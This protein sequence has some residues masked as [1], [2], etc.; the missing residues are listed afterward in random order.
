[1][2]LY[3]DSLQ[4]TKNSGHQWWTSVNLLSQEPPELSHQTRTTTT[5][6]TIQTWFRPKPFKCRWTWWT[7]KCWLWCSSSNSIR[8]RAMLPACRVWQSKCKN[9]NLCKWTYRNRWHLL[10]CH[11]LLRVLKVIQ[12]RCCS[13]SRRRTH[14]RCYK[15]ITVS[16]MKTCQ[17]LSLRLLIT[18]QA[19]QLLR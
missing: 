18:K 1:M 17:I 7:N 8:W 2:T 10:T 15:M 11:P 16:L 6:V 3:S 9:F 4:T 13:K 19:M 5:K 12:C 14:R